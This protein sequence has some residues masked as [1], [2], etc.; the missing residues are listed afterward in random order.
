MANK[1]F[2]AVLTVQLVAAI[3]HFLNSVP[4]KKTYIHLLVKV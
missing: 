4:L 1:I 3:S 2:A